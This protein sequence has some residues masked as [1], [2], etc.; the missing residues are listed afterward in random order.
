VRGEVGGH[1]RLSLTGSRPPS[2]HPRHSPRPRTGTAWPTPARAC[3]PAHGRG[4]GGGSSGWAGRSRET[5]RVHVLFL[6]LHLLFY[7]LPP[8]AHHSPACQ[9]TLVY[10]AT[11]A[12]S[13]MF[14]CSSA[15]PRGVWAARTCLLHTAHLSHSPSGCCCCCCRCGRGWRPVAALVHPTRDEDG[16]C[17]REAEDKAKAQRSQQEVK[18][19]VVRERELGAQDA[20]DLEVV[21]HC[22][23]A[24][25]YITIILQEDLPGLRDAT[26][27]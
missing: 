24:V 10:P 18:A 7:T 5:P 25:G 9:N 26:F 21:G 1:A 2:T 4:G 6:S 15:P 14:M 11:C 22:G 17:R 8:A 13:L 23:C 3:V 20:R 27:L 16:H 19:L 12:H